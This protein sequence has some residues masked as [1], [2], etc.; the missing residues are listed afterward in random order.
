MES[1]KHFTKGNT[2]VIYKK[3]WIFHDLVNNRKYSKLSCLNLYDNE[4][5]VC[6]QP[7]F[8]LCRT[9]DVYA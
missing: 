2:I 1:K 3:Q 4:N 5:Y 6:E 7:H 8:T 9:T